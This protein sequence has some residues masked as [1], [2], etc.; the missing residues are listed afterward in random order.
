MPN[1][2][3]NK[4]SF[5]ALMEKLNLVKKYENITISDFIGIVG[6]KCRG[7]VRESSHFQKGKYDYRVNVNKKISNLNLIL[8]SKEAKN[9]IAIYNFNNSFEENDISVSLSA[10]DIKTINQ[11]METAP[12]L[13]A[14]I[15]E[16]CAE[17]FN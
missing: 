15:N 1:T 10:E 8:F 2:I 17:C 3:M 13:D 11:I 16:N 9:L 12:E 6:T 5:N 14:F 7:E 4:E